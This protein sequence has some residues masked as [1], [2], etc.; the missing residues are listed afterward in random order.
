MDFNHALFRFDG[1]LR[2][3][4]WWMWSIALVLLQ[5][6]VLR[7]IDTVQFGPDADLQAGNYFAWFVGMTPV[8]GPYWNGLA[9]GL[10]LLWPT[11]A[12]TLKRAHDRNR[13]GW[14]LVLIQVVATASTVLPADVFE[15]AGRAFDAADYVAA[16]PVIV[17]GVLLLIASLYQL[18]VLGFLDGTPGPNRFG[19]SP[20]G[21]GGDTAEVFS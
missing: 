17:F 19:R 8:T 7:V 10:V 20:K 21:A 3:R 18:V 4:D 5:T 14:D 11:L 9:V 13:P 2:R 12:L 6:L 16:A 1:R 15:T